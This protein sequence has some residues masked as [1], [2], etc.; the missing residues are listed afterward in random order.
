MVVVFNKLTSK[1]TIW[2]EYKRQY[3]KPTAEDENSDKDGNMNTKKNDNHNL[4][5]DV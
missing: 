4:Y 3:H 2:M 5:R 1:K